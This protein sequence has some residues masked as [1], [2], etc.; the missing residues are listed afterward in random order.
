VQEPGVG[1]PAPGTHSTGVDCV[2]LDHHRREVESL[3]EQG[4]LLVEALDDKD[5]EVERLRESNNNLRVDVAVANEEVNER[6]REI[7]RLRGALRAT[8][9]TLHDYADDLRKA[10]DEIGRLRL[11]RDAAVEDRNEGWD[12]V[13]RLREVVNDMYQSVQEALNHRVEEV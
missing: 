9:S 2:P 4:G 8:E 11:L 13:E 1:T 3:R 5:G 12:E 6:G 10:K 7:E